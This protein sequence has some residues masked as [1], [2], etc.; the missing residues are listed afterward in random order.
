M[1]ANRFVE[2]VASFEFQMDLI[3][4]LILSLAVTAIAIDYGYMLYLRSRMP[5]G[6]FPFPIIGNTFS[7]PNNKPWIYFEELSKK[8]NAPL[9]TFWI[10]RSVFTLSEGSSVLH[11]HVGRGES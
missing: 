2:R 1:I 7:L 11:I 4:P 3:V 6:P 9:I 8:Y 10:G 5:P